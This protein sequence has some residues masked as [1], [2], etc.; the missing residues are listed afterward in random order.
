MLA[1]LLRSFD[2]NMLYGRR[3]LADLSDE[4]FTTQPVAG[5]NHAAWIVGHL[6]H[7]FEMIGGE[8]GLPPWLPANW[9]DY[10]GTGSSP[11]PVQAGSPGR[12][13]LLSALADS[14]RRLTDALKAMPDAHLA[15]PL[16]DE[17]YRRIF[18]TLGSAVLHILTVHAAVHIGQLSAWR[19]AMR[20]PPVID[21]M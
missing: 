6:C 17:R 5:M 8:L 4:Q 14:Q 19:R 20:L 9:A 10:F 13:Q 16:P 11:L 18:P 2:M 7:S 1:E 21:P 15:R 12:I 3:L